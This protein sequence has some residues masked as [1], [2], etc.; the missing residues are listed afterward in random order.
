[1]TFQDDWSY[2][3]CMTRPKR[4]E[5][6]R[7]K[8]LGQGLKLFITQGYHGTGIKE[9]VDQVKVPK[10]SF[11]NYFE[12]KEQFGAEVIRQYSEQIIANMAAYLNGPEDNALIALKQFFEQEMQRHQEVKAGCIIGNLGA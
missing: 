5:N 12:S 10:G 1:M 8:L 9:V 11:Y 3:I 6:I 2:I 7:E 4:N